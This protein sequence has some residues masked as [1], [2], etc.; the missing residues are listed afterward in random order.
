MKKIVCTECPIGCDVTVEFENGRI[1]RVYGNSCPRGRA[2]SIAEVTNP[3]RVV[4]TT[5]K[6]N[7]DKMIAVKTSVP[8][9]RENIFKVIEIAKGIT[10]TLPVKIGQVVI[11]NICDRAD[12]IVASNV[13]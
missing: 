6:S 10:M 3:L 7:K 2:Y 4:T 1:E 9:R 11:S 13:E 5:V 8:V 12:L